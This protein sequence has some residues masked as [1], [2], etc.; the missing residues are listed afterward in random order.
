MLP[1]IS[2][3]VFT[4]VLACYT[5]RFLSI[6]VADPSYILLDRN[7]ISVLRRLTKKTFEEGRDMYSHFLQAVYPSLQSYG[8]AFEALI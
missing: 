7:T 5:K 6:S 4:A 3:E 2:S 1:A 8:P